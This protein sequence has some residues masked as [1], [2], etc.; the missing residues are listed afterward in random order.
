MITALGGVSVGYALSLRATRHQRVFQESESEKDRRF[1]E[2]QRV[3]ELQENAAHEFAHALN[4]AGKEVP[5]GLL[6]RSTAAGR[7]AKCQQGIREG[8]GT[9][10]ASLRDP[11]IEQANRNLDEVL[12]IAWQDCGTDRD[13]EENFFPIGLAFSDLYDAI[14]AFIVREDPPE[15]RLP[16]SAQLIALAYPDGENLGLEGIRRWAA[17]NGQ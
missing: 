6:R 8:W 9:A 16:P 2:G 14:S 3:R 17:E 1:R 4:E 7:I 15:M 12:F 11:A 5:T 13:A 10:R